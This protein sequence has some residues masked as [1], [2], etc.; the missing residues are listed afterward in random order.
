MNLLISLLPVVVFMAAVTVGISLLKWF[1]FFGVILPYAAAAAFLGGFVY[2][3]LRWAHSPVPFHIPAI[4]GQQKS[5]PWIRASRTGSPSTT[6]GVIGR[7]AAE[8]LFFR[9]LLENEKVELKSV[10]QLV[11]GTN[12]YLWLGGLA[13]HWS[14]LVILLRHTRFFLEPV[15]WLVLSVHWLDGVF[16]NL[17]P[18]LFVTDIFILISLTYLFLRRALLPQLRHLS[19]PS[20]YFV[21]FVLL[22]IVLSGLLMRLFFKVDLVRVKE[23]AMGMLSFHPL[24][25]AGVNLLFYL[26]LFLVA[27]LIAYFPHSKLMHMAGVFLSPTRNLQNRSRMERHLNP[28]N[29]PVEVHTYPSYEDEFRAVMKEAGLPVEKE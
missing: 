24:V 7:M 28:W 17:L 22:S 18:I 1:T 19:L 26:H 9:S 4:C 8:I 11:Y 12:I 10:R 14:L 15:P 5:L 16:Q 27:V 20:D 6:L 29:P 23:W 13:F 21:L 2:R 3:I 25:P